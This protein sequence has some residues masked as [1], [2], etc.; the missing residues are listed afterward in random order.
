LNLNALLL[1]LEGLSEEQADA[2][3]RRVFAELYTGS[4]FSGTMG[5]HGGG[6]ATFFMDRWE[7]HASRTSS[8]RAKYPYAKDKIALDRIARVKWIKEI[9]AG[10]V[11]GTECWHVRPQSG[12]NHPLDRL[13]VHWE[14]GYVV[15]LQPRMDGG[16]RFSS[17]FPAVKPEIK[18]FIT[19]GSL[20]WRIEKEKENAP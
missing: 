6:T 18:R 8:D 19:G 4:G 7:K 9:L 16:W 13:Y 1:P 17:A 11:P 10:S 2:E 3:G 14:Y 15:W 12:R 5:L 20:Q